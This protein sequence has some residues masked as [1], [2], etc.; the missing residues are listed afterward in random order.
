MDTT[1]LQIQ[2]STPSTP[3]HYTWAD[4]SD[5]RFGF[6]YGSYTFM[7]GN[8]Y[9]LFYDQ[10][11]QWFANYTPAAQQSPD[12]N[13][14]TPTGDPRGWARLV[15]EVGRKFISIQTD[16]HFRTRSVTE[17]IKAPKDLLWD[18]QLELDDLING[19]RA[20]ERPLALPL[21]A[22]GVRSLMNGS[23][24][25]PTAGIGIGYEFLGYSLSY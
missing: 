21:I 1:G 7:Y 20:S 13:D 14:L 22:I 19:G 18:I 11:F 25:A 4:W 10:A 24:W 15:Y 6:G 17:T 8:P 12:S 3:T 23:W 5:Y 9:S 2:V 16:Y